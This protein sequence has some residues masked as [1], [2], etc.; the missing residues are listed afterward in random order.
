LKV[1]GK[2]WDNAPLAAIVLSRRHFWGGSISASP[3]DSLMT[4][5]QTLAELNTVALKWSLLPNPEFDLTDDIRRGTFLLY[6][7]VF[8]FGAFAGNK[9]DGRA[10]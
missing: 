2:F 4:N 7:R 8:W 6:N 9:M 3:A 5:P 1:D 10:V